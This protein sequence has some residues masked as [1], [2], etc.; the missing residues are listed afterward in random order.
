MP[1]CSTQAAGD[2]P[3]THLN[4]QVPKGVQKSLFILLSVPYSLKN[5][6]KIERQEKLS[7][8]N[9]EFQNK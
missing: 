8:A 1:H 9:Q 7:C 4:D 2:V 6:S 3:A 5:R